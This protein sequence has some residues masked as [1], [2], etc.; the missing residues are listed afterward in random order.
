MSDLLRDV[1][2]GLRRATQAPGVTLLAALTIT[3]G[4]GGSTA[5]FSVLDR[6]MLRSLPVAQ[7]DRL[8]IFRS[9]GSVET[10]DVWWPEARGYFDRAESVLAG[11][12]SVYGPV[13]MAV[14]HPAGSDTLSI[15][16]ASP[17]FFSLLGI[18][19][20]AGRLFASSDAD[21]GR[22]VAVLGHDFWVRR[23]GGNPRVVGDALTIQGAPHVIVGVAPPGF[24]GIA[25]GLKPDVYAA[26]S[27][28]SAPRW[29]RL[30]ARLLPGVTLDQ[31]RTA[32]DGPFRSAR[33]ASGV[34]DV[35][36]PQGLDRLLVEPAARGVSGL[37]DRFGAATWL[38][39]G[40][41]SLVLLVSCANVATLVLTHADGRRTELAVA[42]AL[43]AGRGR[44]V[45]LLLVE[46]LVPVALGAGA[47]LLGAHWASRGLVAALAFDDPRIAL[48]VSLDGRVL[49]FAALALVAAVL[50][51]ALLPGLAASRVDPIEELKRR[52][53]LSGRSTGAWPRGALVVAQVALSV[54]VLGCAALLIRS[55]V[56]LASHD[57]GW[58]PDRVL[59]AS[60]S[61]ALPARTGPQLGDAVVELMARVSRVPG[62]ERVSQTAVAPMSGT[63]IGITVRNDD[64]GAAESR[65]TFFTSVS[66]R[67][68]ATL[69]TPIVAGRDFTDQEAA[70]GEPVVI[71]NQ[72]LAARLF[73]D[74]LP[75]GRRV[76]FAEGR[77]PPMTIVGVAAD[78]TQNEVREASRSFLYLPS[79]L[80]GARMPRTTVLIRST[81]TRAQVIAGPVERAL[82]AANLGVSVEAVRPLSAYVHDDLRG[83]RLVA[84]LASAFGLLALAVTSVGLFSVVSAAVANRTQEFGLRAALGATGADIV[85]LVLRPV[86]GFVGAGLALGAAGAWLAATLF[87]RLL[88]GATALDAYGF[89]GVAF[90]LVVSAGAAAWLPARRAALVDPNVAL[91]PR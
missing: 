77:R 18:E 20:A 33:A 83:D 53:R 40:V 28:A 78:A 1:R 72:H 37:R 42:R 38:L 59:V 12:T 30:F 52:D 81:D 39:M 7:P 32:L 46:G 87:S 66:P 64:E 58:E 24:H 79:R 16:Q 8:V 68:F 84:Q 36:W 67:Y 21:D 35:E 10:N 41:V 73:G 89:A 48:D 70:A 49:A 25:V 15:V 43:G 31:A 27:P 4:V 47:G 2:L 13:E 85:W 9:A 80:A 51:A 19:P 14:G 57:L 60:L 5:V 88:F 71:I 3:L 55:L 56:N 54:A 23:L 63:E 74:S 44:L 62:V 91:R 69:G 76:R 45:R 26:I 11:T 29:S 90:V 82:R 65:H 86:V 17:E 6:L 34:P 22:L 75:V 61:D 50:A